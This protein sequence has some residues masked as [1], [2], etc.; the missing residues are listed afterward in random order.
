M[1]NEV[2]LD[3]SE[4]QPPLPMEMAMDAIDALKQGQYI[5]MIHRMQ[6]HPLYTILFEN[7]FKYKVAENNDLFNIYIWKAADKEAD[8]Q[9]KNLL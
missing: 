9:V 3:V 2:I 8:K 7:G 5:K 6:P 1:S 4:L